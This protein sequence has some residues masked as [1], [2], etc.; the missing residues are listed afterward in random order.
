[1]NN[2]ERAFNDFAYDVIDDAKEILRKKGKNA[3]GNLSDMDYEISIGK[4]SF[5]LSFD[6]EDYWE[7]VDRGVKGVVGKIVTGKHQ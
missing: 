2:I 1:M 5:S 4:N 3:S 7:F 6:L